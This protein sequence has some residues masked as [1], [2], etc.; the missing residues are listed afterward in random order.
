[1]TCDPSGGA[2]LRSLCLGASGRPRAARLRELGV[3]TTGGQAPGEEGGQHPL[4]AA[5]ERSRQGLRTMSHRPAASRSS[6]RLLQ[7]HTLERAQLVPAAR[8]AV[9]DFF[10]DP[11]NLESITPPWLSFRV[12]SPRPI[13]MESGALIEYRLRLHGLPI[14][15]L[16]R[17]AVWEPGHRFVDVQVRGPYRLW[18]HTHVFE[19]H[20]RG[21]LVLDD[22]RYALPLGPLGRLAHAALVRRD[23]ERIFDF[24]REAVARLLGAAR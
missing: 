8:D 23:L 4:L 3:E 11:F 20:E 9:F 18:R 6:R 19:R 10:A 13:A 21:T 15:W 16:A 7:I 24:R 17:V 12:L 22:V 5:C 1:M 14:R 2:E